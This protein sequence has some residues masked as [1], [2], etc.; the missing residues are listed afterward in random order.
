MNGTCTVSQKDKRRI[1]DV[2][3]SSVYHGGGTVDDAGA[4]IFTFAGLQCLPAYTCSESQAMCVPA[5]IDRD[6]IKLRILRALPR[7][8]QQ[9][10]REIN[11]SDR[12]GKIQIAITADRQGGI[13]W[14]EIEAGLEIVIGIT[15]AQCVV[16]AVAVVVE[17][18]GEVGHPQLTVILALVIQCLRSSCAYAGISGNPAP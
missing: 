11:H 12:V 15:Q 17:P 2:S 8:A 3:E 5:V 1:P 6:Q 7:I 10:V 9:P 4:V 16:P 13:F 14:H 18:V